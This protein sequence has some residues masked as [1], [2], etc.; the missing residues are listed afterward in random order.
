MVRELNLA[1][2][3][4]F[5]YTIWASPGSHRVCRIIVAGS[6]DLCESG[7]DGIPRNKNDVQVGVF[8]DNH[9]QIDR[10]EMNLPSIVDLPHDQMLAPHPFPPPL[11]ASSDPPALFGYSSTADCGCLKGYLS[12][13]ASFPPSIPRYPP[14]QH[15]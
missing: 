11:S 6:R 10:G 13:S 12:S 14:W 2:P 3:E 9:E 15:D 7:L 5:V 4:D 8:G 1:K